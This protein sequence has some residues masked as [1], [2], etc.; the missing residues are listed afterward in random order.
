MLSTLLLLSM[1][2]QADTL[3]R[4]ERA[5]TLEEL[6][7]SATRT[8]RRVQDEPTRVEV[9]GREEIVEKLLMTPGDIQ[10]LLNESSG[11]RV[12]NTSPSLGSAN[13]RI[14]GLRGRYTRIL[15]DGLPLAGIQTEGLGLLQIPPMDLGKVEVVKGVASPF[16]GGSAVGGVVNL[17]SRAPQGTDLLA[18][19]TTLG[20]S[21]LVGWHGGSLSSSVAGSILAGYHEQDR[22][23]RDGDGWSDVPGYRRLVARPRVTWTAASGAT[24]FAT[25]GATVEDRD[26]GTLPGQ[27][28]PDGRPFPEALASER[29]D[30]G[31]VARIPTG[32]GV[33]AFRGSVTS[34][35]RDH[36]RGTERERDR[37]AS[38]FSEAT[39][40]LPLSGGALVVGAAAEGDLYRNTDVAGF[41][42]D[43]WT[44][45]AFGQYDWD[46]SERL[47]LTLTAR[48]DHHTEAGTFLSP[49]IAGRWRVADDWSVRISAGSGFVAPTPFIEETEAIGLAR[50]VPLRGLKAERLAGGTID[51][52]G[53]VAGIELHGTLFGSL[54]RH[55]ISIRPAEA[56]GMVELANGQAV[57]RTG[58]AEF[59]A[60]AEAG[61]LA[62]TL[63][64]TGVTATELAPDDSLR[65]Q[66]PLNPRHALGLVTVWEHERGRI[67]LET[68][69]TGTQRLDDNP[70]RAESP[71]Y[72]II[73]VLAEQ[74]I[75]PFRLFLNLENLTDRRQTRWDP[76]VRPSRGA[77]G[78]WTVDLYAPAEGRVVNGGV[79]LGL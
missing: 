76:I 20:G 24:V 17:V 14:Q 41:D 74:T 78:R 77:D 75:G 45:G 63:T 39:R 1:L 42:D 2:P 65:R 12:Q 46:P 51:V 36:T 28:A 62:F 31:I 43:Q 40:T 59:L 15:S 55:P 47:G 19:F 32:S 72:L 35:R 56:E 18:N 6:T 9:L 26:G 73:G 57:T 49:R 54:L 61:P 71:D 27:V 33:W 4:R 10:M 69:Y 58:G 68:F 60:R 70:Y 50:L 67:G 48:L 30:G 64:W 21:D 8:N 38:I 44:I 11:L 3:P 37:R 23:D 22:R 34:Q 79:R 7:V 25:A 66:V 5:D 29:F 52:A 53:T 13:L 16:Y